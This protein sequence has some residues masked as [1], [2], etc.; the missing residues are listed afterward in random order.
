MLEQFLA[1]VAVSLSQMAL[2]FFKHA[3]VRAIV[4][5]QIGR[6]MVYTFALQSA[7][8]ISSALGISAFLEHDY[9]VIS[10]YLCSGVFGAWLN[11]KIKA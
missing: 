6:S 1:I 7:W 3:T 5:N 8:L 9:L 2:I 10:F 11:F 4:A